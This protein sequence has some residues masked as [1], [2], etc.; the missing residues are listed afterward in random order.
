MVDERK[1]V[2]ASCA[3]CSDHRRE[4]RDPELLALNHDSQPLNQQ[5]P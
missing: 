3:L 4:P 2:G 1:D 5:P